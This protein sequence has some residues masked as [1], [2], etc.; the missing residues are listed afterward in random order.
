MFGG[1]QTF[2]QKVP[3]TPFYKAFGPC[4]LRKHT[5]AELPYEMCC[6]RLLYL[7]YCR[8]SWTEHHFLVFRKNSAQ[9]RCL[10]VM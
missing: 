4:A 1:M 9:G 10:T 5:S 2:A 6:T 7:W 8:N 3:V